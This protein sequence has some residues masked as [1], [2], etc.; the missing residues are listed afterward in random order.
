MVL[1]D[2]DRFASR[3]QAAGFTDTQ[4]RHGHHAFGFQAIRPQT[5][6]SS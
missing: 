2:P 4:V 1:V 5:P 6:L 3:L